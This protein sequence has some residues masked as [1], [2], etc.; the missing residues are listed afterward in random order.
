MTVRF[1]AKTL[2]ALAGL[3]FLVQGCAAPVAPLLPV[4]FPAL[5]AGA[6]GGISY[7][8]TNIAYRTMARSV[9][10]VEAAVLQ[11]GSKMSLKVSGVRHKRHKTEIKA[12]T[13]AH[14]IKITL[15]RLTPTLTK[16]SVNA[17]R[18][19]VFKDKTTAF[20]IIYQTEVALLGPDGVDRGPGGAPE[21]GGQGL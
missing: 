5:I 15:E 2:S 1:G 17:K 4:A 9:E 8:L 14:S 13:R 18:G 3:L 6:G 10:E 16:I 21:R 19:W 11:A 12:S 7:T 20:E